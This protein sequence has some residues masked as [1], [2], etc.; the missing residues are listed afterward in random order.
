MRLI[1]FVCAVK[2][3]EEMRTTSITRRRLRESAFFGDEE[4]QN[5]T[6]D[7]I[8]LIELSQE[9]NNQWSYVREKFFV[10]SF[11]FVITA[12]F[13]IAIVLPI[14]VAKGLVRIV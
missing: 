7:P 2:A 12:M 14:L 3:Q 6:I 4:D 10:R 5:T 11:A 1:F 13:S 9:S 8:T